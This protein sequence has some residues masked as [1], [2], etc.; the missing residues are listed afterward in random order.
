[1]ATV[2]SGINRSGICSNFGNCSIADSRG[3]VEVTAGMDFV[4]TECARP[5][6]LKDSNGK[7]ASG[8]AGLIVAAIVILSLLAGAV[9][10]WSGSKKTEDA[11]PKLSPPV[12]STAPPVP[13]EKPSGHCSPADEKA[14]ICKAAR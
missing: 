4:C 5:L 13:S 1:M 14:G 6:L 11:A 9:A 10:W 3:T 8:R 7:R 12:T 2:A